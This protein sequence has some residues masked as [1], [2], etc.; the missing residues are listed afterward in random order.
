MSTPLTTTALRVGIKVCHFAAAAEVRS[1]RD[2]G[3]R[4]MEKR[5]QEIDLHGFHPHDDNL[6]ETIEN[7]LQ[8]AFE[9]E[10]HTLTIIHGHGFNRPNAFRPFANTN[11]GYLG[12]TVRGILRQ[13]PQLRQ[14]MLARIDVRHNGSTTVR[15]RPKVGA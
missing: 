5:A 13:C 12:L 3:D 10:A 2:E 14:W 8:E 9:K 1:D 7:A 15:I 6:F 11:T 4:H